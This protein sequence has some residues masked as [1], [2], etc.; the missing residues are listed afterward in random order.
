VQGI[1]AL[2]R[3]KAHQDARPQLEG[4]AKRLPEEAK[5][6]AE[7]LSHGK[8][9][10]NPTEKS[11]AA[12]DRLANQS[13]AV[14]ASIKAAGLRTPQLASSSLS[15]SGCTQTRVPLLSGLVMD[16]L[17]QRLQRAPADFA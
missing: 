13:V 16:L 2:A 3:T 8:E 12:K 17:H 1:T 11:P 4:R 15:S 6:E 7:K 14:V 5:G 9:R 10:E